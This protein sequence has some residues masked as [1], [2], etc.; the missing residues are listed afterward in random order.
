MKK[1]MSLG[2]EDPGE[3]FFV[4]LPPEL[5][6]FRTSKLGP[7]VFF[8]FEEPQFESLR[9]VR[10]LAKAAGR[11]TLSTSQ[12]SP[13]EEL[14]D[15]RVYKFF[16]TVGC[17]GARLDWNGFVQKRRCPTCGKDYEELDES[18]Q[19][20]LDLSAVED[21]LEPLFSVSRGIVITAGFLEQLRPFDLLA[22]AKLLDLRASQSCF[23]LLSSVDLG[24]ETW[25]KDADRCASCGRL[26]VSPGFF[27]LFDKPAA[28]ADLYYSRQYSPLI[29]IVGGKLGRALRGPDVREANLWFCGWYPDDLELAR[30]PSLD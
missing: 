16:S 30:L 24:L 7:H 15:G 8:G 18:A 6:G 20:T 21:P 2:V 5:A 11:A 3:D 19:P 13:E 9:A 23:L 26:R 4:S 10:R 17:K 1:Y 12:F 14:Q 22:G 25:E 28:R 29:P 27:P